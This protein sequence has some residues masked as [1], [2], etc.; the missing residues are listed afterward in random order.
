MQ[1]ERYRTMAENKRIAELVRFRNLRSFQATLLVHDGTVVFCERFVDLAAGVSE[2]MLFT[3]KKSVQHIAA[4]CGIEDHRHEK[5]LFHA[6]EAGRCLL[7]LRSHYDGHLDQLDVRRWHLEEHEALVVFRRLQS[8]ADRPDRSDFFA[9]SELM[10]GKFANTQIC[11]I[12]RTLALLAELNR[13][14]GDSCAAGESG[15]KSVP[16]GEHNRN[17]PLC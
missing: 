2:E 8:V 10:P 5:V 1:Q 14:Y 11:L 3:A 12:D 17:A 16:S 7:D 4:G 13:R 6:G 9:F 15:E